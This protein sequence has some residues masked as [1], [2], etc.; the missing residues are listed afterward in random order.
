MKGR[1]ARSSPLCGLQ[2]RILRACGYSAYCPIIVTLRLGMRHD[3]RSAVCLVGGRDIMRD[4]QKEEVEDK[5][6]RY[7][8]KVEERGEHSPW[9]WGRGSFS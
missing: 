9:L 5:V 8:T 1:G 6:Q 7:R 2:M 4:S 3:I